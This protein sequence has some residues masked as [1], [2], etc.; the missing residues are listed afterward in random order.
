MEQEINK[1]NPISTNRIYKKRAMEVGTFIGGPI[2]LGY[3]IA[4]NFKVFNEP[5]KVRLTWIYTIIVTILIFGGVFLIP[6]IDKIPND[7][8]PLI[9]TGI[10]ILLVNRYQKEKIDKHIGLGGLAYSWWR[11]IGIA[12]IALTITIIPILTIAYFSVS[13]TTP[14]ITSKTYGVIKNEIDFDKSNISESEID[15]LADG[16]TKIDFF[17]PVQKKYVYV[18]K[19]GNNYEISISC[20]NKIENNVDLINAF[21]QLRTEMQTLFPNNKIIFNLVVD[22]IHNVVKR[23]E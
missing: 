10:G 1:P 15:K 11:T 14:T 23:L 20:N 19:I 12:L 4:E 22:D 18:N 5:E 16:F 8:I 7:L 17:N 3:F 21:A 6:K 9:Y 13:S 2:A